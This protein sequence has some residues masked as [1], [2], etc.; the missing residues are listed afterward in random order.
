MGAEYQADWNSDCTLL[1]CAFP[2]TPKFRQVEADGGT[3]IRKEWISECYKNKKLVDIESFLMHTGKPWRRQSISCQAREDEE[4]R[5]TRKAPQ[6]VE[7]RLHTKST[8]ASSSKGATTSHGKD[9]FKAGELKKWAMNDL[10]K[11]ISWLETQDEKP[12]AGEIKKI[13]A[14]GVL[15]CLQDAIDSLKQG[16][17]MSQI[18]DQWSCIPRVVEELIKLDGLRSVSKKDLE[19]Q[20]ISYKEIYEA[21]FG[22]LNGS[23]TNKKKQNNTKP[24]NYDSDETIEMTEEEIDEAYKYVASSRNT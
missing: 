4:H 9:H 24:T 11:T 23:L 5:A 21:E 1:I 13:A 10:E 3:I 19:K 16:Q 18:T 8:A 2:N 6:K 12:D 17:S 15:T 22:K 20:A 7:S 14:E